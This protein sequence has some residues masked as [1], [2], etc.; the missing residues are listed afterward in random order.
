MANIDS[1]KVWSRVNNDPNV[2]SK[3]LHVLVTGAAGQI[4]YNLLFLIAH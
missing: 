1:N 2:E 3:P 4:G